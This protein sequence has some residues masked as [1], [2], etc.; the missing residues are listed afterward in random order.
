MISGRKWLRYATNFH[1]K[2]T[3]FKH[4]SFTWK[5]TNRLLSGK[6]K[7]CVVN[8]IQNHVAT[9]S[10][11]DCWAAVSATSEA[12]DCCMWWLWWHIRRCSTGQAIIDCV[13]AERATPQLNTVRWAPQTEIEIKVFSTEKW[14]KKGSNTFFFGL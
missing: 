7:K 6:I 2:L 5:W 14:M 4:S 13:T 1:V 9:S 10:R 12:L 3:F 11:K 8:K